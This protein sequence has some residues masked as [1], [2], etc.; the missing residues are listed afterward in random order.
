MAKHAQSISRE[1]K[2]AREEQER[3]IAH[4]IQAYRIKLVKPDAEWKPLKTLCREVAEE[5]RENGKPV[6]QKAAE[7]EAV[8]LETRW[9]ERDERACRKAYKEE[10]TQW[11]AEWAK[12]KVEKWRQ[13]WIKPKLGKLEALLPK[14]TI[15]HVDE[16]AAEESESDD[17]EDGEDNC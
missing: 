1:K 14:P 7:E 8:A 15:V 12:A 2:L 6:V 16:E 17:G 10:L 5:W 4:A 9:Q 3:A 13:M 11:E